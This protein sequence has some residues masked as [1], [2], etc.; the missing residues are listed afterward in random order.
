[1]ISS[2][3]AGTL[4]YHLTKHVVC[5]KIKSHAM[6]NIDRPNEAL[7]DIFYAAYSGGTWSSKFVEIYY[8]T[9]DKLLLAS[10][11]LRLWPPIHMVLFR[12]KIKTHTSLSANVLSAV[13][14]SVF[15]RAEISRKTTQGKIKWKLVVSARDNIY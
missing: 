14:C 3:A 9:L 8:F 15:T 5:N 4:N 2:A 11:T 10:S 7:R 1:M 13:S 6:P 12:N